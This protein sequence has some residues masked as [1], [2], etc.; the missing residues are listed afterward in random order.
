MT[1]RLEMKVFP[2]AKY[3]DAYK[4]SEELLKNDK[5]AP[6]LEAGYYSSCESEPLHFYLGESLLAIATLLPGV[7]IAELHKFY[8][9]PKARG[10]EI[11]LVAARMAIDHLFSAHEA[12][13]V[14]VHMH[15]NS[16][17][18]WE[19]VVKIYAERAVLIEPNCYFFAPGQVARD[20][21]PCAFGV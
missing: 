8:V 6:F 3:A 11:G 2:R 15:G 13:K 12:E 17:G 9:H 10:R 21:Y 1:Q 19:R 7:E 18:F 5:S 14:I 4:M 16:E 20:H